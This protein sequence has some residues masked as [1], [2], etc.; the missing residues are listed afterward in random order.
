MDYR[1]IQSFFTLSYRQ[2]EINWQELTSA[3]SSVIVRFIPR[4]REKGVTFNRSSCRPRRFELSTKE[5]TA[6]LE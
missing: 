1:T 4:T 2:L 6:P 3:L 5:I